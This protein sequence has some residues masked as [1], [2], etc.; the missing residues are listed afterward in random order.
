MGNETDILIRSLQ[1]P[2]V[3][4][5]EV[6]AIKL[7][8]THISWVILT[9]PYAYKIKKP[10]NL[11]FLD[12]SSLV[13][14]K[15]YCEEE[16][17]LNS[18]LAPDIYLDVVAICGTPDRPV[19]NGSGPAIEYAVRMKQFDPDYELDK[20]LSRNELKHEHIRVLASKVATF[21][22]S[23]AKA[24]PSTPYGSPDSILGPCIENLDQ[25]QS[26]LSD[27]QTH[28]RLKQIRQWT[29]QTWATL[30]PIFEHR[31]TEGYIR[32]CHGDLHLHNL[33][34]VQD[35]I[36]IFDCI[37]F[38]PN[39]YWIDVISEIS[40]TV[41]DLDSRHQSSH[42]W[43]FLNRYLQ[44]T[45]DYE[46]IRLLRYYLLYR[47]M[48]RAKV[49]C[50][51]AHQENVGHSDHDQ[52]MAE[53][54]SYLSLAEK[55]LCKNQPVLIIMHGLSGSGKTTVA[56]DLAIQLGAVHVRSDIERKR[57]SGMT[58][59]QRSGSST[60][61]GL[62]ASGVSDKTYDRLANITS[63]TLKSGYHIIVDASFLSRSKRQQF[64]DLAI[65]LETP[66][67]L[68]NCQAPKTLLKER[69]IRRYQSAAD[70]SEAN[71]QVLDHQLKMADPL[72]EKEKLH[73]IYL[74]TN[75]P[76]D[77]PQLLSSLDI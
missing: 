52:I 19:L 50:I 8:E 42:A 41:M 49:D 62:Y 25:I 46:G 47:A 7:V 61:D 34:L 15:Y 18:R 76:I 39:L 63:T 43:L 24:S 68:I 31:K 65:Q 73:S 40:F 45:G 77:I 20:L 51:R 60:D 32:E 23:I 64:Y 22:Q 28:S 57:L 27:G 71:A 11:V 10:V 12:F 66:L 9:G 1:N 3:Y 16:M 58:E 35:D 17:R 30:K 14:R 48:V 75:Q 29:S 70:A 55:Y 38:N 56:D 26:L 6:T 53:F 37:D 54:Q 21:H 74:D 2:V 36:L 59:T 5:H 33:A 13:K 4:P 69:I 72:D 44:L 67:R